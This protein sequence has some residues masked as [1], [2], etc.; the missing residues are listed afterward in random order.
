VIPTTPKD[1]KL[2]DSFDLRWFT[3]THEVNLCGHAT[4]ATAFVI[5]TVVGNE[6]TELTFNTKSGPLICRRG[7]GDRNLVIMEF[8]Q[9]SFKSVSLNEEPWKS[10]ASLTVQGAPLSEAVFAP[11]CGKLLLVLDRSNHLSFLTELKPNLSELM[12]SFPDGPVRGICVSLQAGAADGRDFS[13][14]YFAPWVGLDED[15]VTGS[16]HCLSGPYWSAVLDKSKLQ[17]RQCSRRGGDLVLQLRE[18]GR[19]EIGG[20]ACLVEERTLVHEDA[21][22]VF[23]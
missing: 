13:S 20:V 9:Y 16:A 10:L 11:E 7:S 15:P 3:P 8:P 18:D 6:N 17:A 19:I 2:S 5:F 12:R 23:A 21:T 1:A 22:R 4:L 14:R